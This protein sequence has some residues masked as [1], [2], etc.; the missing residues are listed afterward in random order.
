MPL[1]PEVNLALWLFVLQL[2]LN[3]SWSWAFFGNRST[4][5]GL[6]VIIPF[7]IA[8]ILSALAFAK[9]NTSAG[10]LMLPYP[11]WVAFATY[12]NTTM[13]WLNRASA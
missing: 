12:L 3:P 7:L 10:W 5:T 6:V 11:L 4:A 2:V 1:S 13:W 8:V 9:V